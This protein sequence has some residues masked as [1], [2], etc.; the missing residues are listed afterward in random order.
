MRNPRTGNYV[1]RDCRYIFHRSSLQDV[2][3]ASAHVPHSR[4]CSERKPTVKLDQAPSVSPDSIV[5][6][7]QEAD[8]FLFRNKH[9]LRCSW[10]AISQIVPLLRIYY[11]VDQDSGYGDIGS[12]L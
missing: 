5:R 8:A 12:I 4:E 10:R 6:T 11:S 2:N 3:V 1:D 7:V 9:R